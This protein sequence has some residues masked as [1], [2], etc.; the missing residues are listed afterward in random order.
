MRCSQSTAIV[1]PRE[2]MFVFGSA[3]RVFTSWPASRLPKLEV[4]RHEVLVGVAALGRGLEQRP[5]VPRER[6]LDAAL[7]GE[8]EHEVDVLEHHRRRERR[9]VV[10]AR[11]SGSTLYAHERRA[12]RRGADHLEQPRPLDTG[13]FAEHERLAE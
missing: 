1:A 13:G 3:H 11:A 7:G 8:V 5:Q 10:V 2:A 4:Q 9:G 12:D 6:E